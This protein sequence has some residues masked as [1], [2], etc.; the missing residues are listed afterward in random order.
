MKRERCYFCL[1]FFHVLKLFSSGPH[2][3]Q[4]AEQDGLLISPSTAI[5]LGL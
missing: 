1:H 5:R 3:K 4:G 2:Q